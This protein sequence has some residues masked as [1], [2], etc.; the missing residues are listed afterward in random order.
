MKVVVV[1]VG[2][3]GDVLPM[4]GLGARLQAAGHEVAVATQELF[5]DAVRDSGP[6]FRALPGDVRPVLDSAGRAWRAAR[7]TAAATRAQMDVGLALQADLSAGIEAATEGADVLLPHYIAEVHAYLVAQARGIPCA[8]LQIFPGMPTAEFLPAMV[9]T[10]SLGR[11]GNRTLPRLAM[12]MRT[13][14]DAGVADFQRRL[15]LPVTGLSA[16]R[17]AM[18]DDERLPVLH[19]YSPALSPR[20][21]DWRPGAEVVGSWWPK[22]APADYAPPAELADFLAAGPAPVFV[23]LGSMAAGEGE[24]VSGIVTGALR[25]AGVRGVVQAGWAELDVRGDDVL[26]V[27]ALPHDWLLPRVAAAV[28]HC[29]SGTTAAAARAGV[30]AVGVPTLADQAF[31]AYRLERVGVS[32]GSVRFRDLSADRLGALVRAA[33][34]E[35]S[36]RE[37][38]K[39]LAVRVQADDGAGRVAEVLDTLP[40]PA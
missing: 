33:V 32:P 25:K 29:G 15:G 16:V 36:Y 13:P 14:L 10:R 24:R 22:P 27:G 37:Q 35:P 7:S 20:P 38:A 18:L 5:A 30:P 8:T 1:A 21:A 4:I 19:G 11:W 6:E 39:E 31:W 12:R 23:G 40:R 3:Q 26:T 2:S 17:L 34:T 9:G 28:H